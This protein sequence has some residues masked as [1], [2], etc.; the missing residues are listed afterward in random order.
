MLTGTMVVVVAATGLLSACDERA[1]SRAAAIVDGQTILESDVQKATREFNTGSSQATQPVQPSNVVSLL[2]YGH[3][4]LPAMQQAGKGISD[5]MAKKYLDKIDD[6]SPAT[7]A[8]V[9]SAVALNNMDDA[10]RTKVAEE[11]RG[12]SI[13]LNP[14]YGTFDPKALEIKP[15][16]RNWLVADATATTAPG[17]P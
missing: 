15:E 9:K 13:K 5:D 8:F 11:L 6:P 1:E 4:V 10:T 14:R 2:T 3:F 12:A 16:A 7:L 17:A